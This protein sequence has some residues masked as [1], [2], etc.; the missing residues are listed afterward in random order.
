MAGDLQPI[1]I[2]DIQHA[3]LFYKVRLEVVFFFVW[4]AQIGLILISNNYDSLLDSK[5]GRKSS[6]K[7]QHTVHTV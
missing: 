6:P 1:P 2:K 7:S 5:G 4:R 3:A